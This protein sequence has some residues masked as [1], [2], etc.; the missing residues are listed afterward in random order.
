MIARWRARDGVL[1]RL[2]FW[3][4]LWRLNRHARR[5]VAEH[6][7]RYGP[8]RAPRADASPEARPAHAGGTSPADPGGRPLSRAR[9]RVVT[10]TPRRSHD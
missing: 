7:A 6:R 4:D 10:L 1:G 3:L 2:V 8:P 9:A 5:V